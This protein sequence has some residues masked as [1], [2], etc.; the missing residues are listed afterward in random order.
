MDLYELSSTDKKAELNEKD[1]CSGK[2]VLSELRQHLL[3]SEQQK[4]SQSIVAKTCFVCGSDAEKSI[5]VGKSV[6][7]IAQ[8]RAVRFS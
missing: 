2:P 6:L 4:I 8:S 1:H 7:E 5:Y 3:S